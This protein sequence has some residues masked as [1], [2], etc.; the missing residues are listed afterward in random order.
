MGETLQ[1]D[2]SRAGNRRVG[3]GEGVLTSGKVPLEKTLQ[4]HSLDAEQMAWRVVLGDHGR[5]T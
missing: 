3:F 2:C 4:G 5:L 1:P